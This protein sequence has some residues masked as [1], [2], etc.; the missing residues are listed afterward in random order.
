MNTKLKPFEKEIREFSKNKHD[1]ID[2]GILLW[3]VFHTVIKDYEEKYPDWIFVKHE[4]L[5]L[6]PLESFRSIYKRLGID[7]TTGIEDK[8]SGYTQSKEE[9]KLKRDSR[10][11]VYSWKKRLTKKE[12]S[13]IILG[14]KELTDYYYN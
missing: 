12:I 13:R 1:I 3:N 5:S 14:T 9:T 7:F 6:N 11:N 10:S 4:E 8:I 2:Q